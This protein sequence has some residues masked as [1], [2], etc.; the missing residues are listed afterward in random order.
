[1]IEQ[2]SDM[3]P[4]DVREAL[5][6]LHALSE[7][8]EPVTSELYSPNDFYGNAHALK[9]YLGKPEGYAVKAAMEHS[10][11]LGHGNW[12]LNVQA[13]L[14]AVISMS[15]Y[16]HAFIRP[17]T[18]KPLYAVGPYVHYAPHALSGEQLA[19]ERKRLGRSLLAFPAHST[20]YVTCE[21]SVDQFCAVLH[22]L[23]RDFDTVRVCMYWKD[24]LNGTAAEYARRGFE[25]VTCGHMFDL[26]FL[27]RLKSLISLASLTVANALTTALGYSVHMGI[28]H[29]YS[30]SII[31]Y[32]CQDEETFRIMLG[33]SHC[34]QASSDIVELEAVFSEFSD[35]VTPRQYETADKYWGL[36]S[37][38][39]REGLADLF[40]ELEAMHG[41]MHPHR[42]G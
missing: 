27:P 11:E 30:P 13:P 35:E 29:Y 8:R 6:P 3:I 22:R 28:P 9:A 18:D 42:A 34:K 20:H 16:R 25:C 14:P 7:E 15:P 19:F 2:C 31:G 33:D 12:M 32:G 39:D 23:G 37:V 17:H 21:H 40:D 26:Q 36:S 1:M 5:L 4:A 10:A 24:V 41:A 38:L